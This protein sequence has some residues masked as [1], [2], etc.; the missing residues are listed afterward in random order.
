[1]RLS[2]PALQPEWASRP[3]YVLQQSPHASTSH[4][5]LVQTISTGSDS[6][7]ADGVAMPRKEIASYTWTDTGF[8]L[9]ILIH[10]SESVPRE[11]VRKEIC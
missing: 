3:P 9:K 8:T 10:L 2:Q 6:V 5:M 1:M 4:A 7:A 11:Q